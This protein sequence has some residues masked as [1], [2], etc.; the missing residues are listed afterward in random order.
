MNFNWNTDKNKILKE[1][2]GVTF[3]DVVSAINDDKVIDI[4]K[5]PNQVK[6]P[7]Q[8]IYI[9]ELFGYVH[10]VPFVKEGEEIFLKTIIPSGKLNKIYGG[11]S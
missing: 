7:K 8:K 10:M 4:I 5:H 6:Y 9:I 1:D 2:R 11:L 3:E